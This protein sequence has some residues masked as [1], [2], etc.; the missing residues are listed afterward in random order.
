MKRSKIDEVRKEFLSNVSH[1]LKTPIALIQGYAEGLQEGISDDPES[2]AFYCDVIVDEAKKMNRMVRKL[3]TLNHLEFGQGC[4]H[5][6]T[7]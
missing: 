2:R 6:R 7:I 1:E 5:R 4:A 3:L